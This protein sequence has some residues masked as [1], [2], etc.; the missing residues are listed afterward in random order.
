MKPLEIVEVSY[1]YGPRN[2]LHGVTFAL[3]E[4]E[5]VGLI[6]P[7]GG[8]KTTL[9]RLILGLAQPYS[10]EIYLWGRN[11][12]KD[13]VVRQRI[14]YLPQRAIYNT[15]FP[16]TAGEAVFLT[17]PRRP[18]ALGPNSSE[19][20][21]IKE[22]LALVGMEKYLDTPLRYL[23]GGQQQL[24]FLAR[25]LAHKPSLLLLDEPTNALDLAAQHRFYNLLAELRQRIN[26]TI[27]AVS[28]DILALAQV[29][30]RF[31]LLD[32]K[33][34]ASGPPSKILYQFFNNP[35]AGAHLIPAQGV[36]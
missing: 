22:A 3:K 4:G 27:L 28:H 21:K 13:P 35:L 31:L 17:L 20:A 11:P 32:K 7:N 18:F 30:D 19:R 12:Y 8:G 36:G 33:I 25:C 29:A 14:G 34:I 10:G 15:H 2:V 1:S 6:G 24:V 5:L 9:L 26:L 23:S 16:L